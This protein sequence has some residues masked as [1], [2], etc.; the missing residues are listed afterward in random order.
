MLVGQD[1]GNPRV[2]DED[3]LRYAICLSSSHRG[4]KCNQ[5]CAVLTANPLRPH[6]FLT[7]PQSERGVEGIKDIHQSLRQI[8]PPSSPLR[9]LVASAQDQYRLSGRQSSIDDWQHAAEPSQVP[10]D[11]V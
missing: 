3:Q 7:K 10:E 6:D 8:L 5:P 11:D 4:H 1:E 9:H 2:S